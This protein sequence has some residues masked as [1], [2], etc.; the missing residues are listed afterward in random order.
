M[1]NGA[2][3]E[4][5][6]IADPAVWSLSRA[7]RKALGPVRT[8]SFIAVLRRSTAVCAELASRRFS[9]GRGRDIHTTHMDILGD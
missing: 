8:C 1:L 2:T 4:S 7:R 9:S 3:W 6:P 5:G